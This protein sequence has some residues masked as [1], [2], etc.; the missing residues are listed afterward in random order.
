MTGVRSTNNHWFAILATG[1]VWIESIPISQKT[2][3]MEINSLLAS[4][5]KGEKMF[6]KELMVAQLLG[7]VWF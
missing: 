4:N 3:R 1:K 5:E 2:Y 7:S 6:K